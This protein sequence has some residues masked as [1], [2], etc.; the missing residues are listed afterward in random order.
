[1]KG[2]KFIDVLA[3]TMPQCIISLNGNCLSSLE[4]DFDRVVL[5]QIK[6]G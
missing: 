4:I 3:A 2:Y 5:S 1:M 6:Y